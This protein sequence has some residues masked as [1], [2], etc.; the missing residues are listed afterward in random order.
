LLVAALVLL[1]VYYVGLAA[2]VLVN[3]ERV[4]ALSTSDRPAQVPGETWLLVGSDSREGLSAAERRR[5]RT[6]SA[7][8]QR[9]DTILLLH[10]P[11]SGSPTL[12]S[13][14]R[15]S[16]LTVPAY[17]RNGRQRGAH[18]DKLNAAYA[19]GGAPLLVRTVEQATGM[20]VDHYMEVGFAGVVGVVDAVGGVDLCVERAI[21]D[22]RAGLDVAAGCQTLD[23]PTA[24]GYV[25]TRYTDAR[26]DLARVE[27]QQ[28]F[29]AALVDAV[30]SPATLVNPI[31]M[32]RLAVAGTDAVR[33]DGGTGP[34]D[35][36]GAARAMRAVSGAR[37]TSRTVPI[38]DPN[39]RT[40]VGSA[41]LWDESEADALFE[42]LREGRTPPRA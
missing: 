22:R 23:G 31:A 13:L 21:R 36:L 11:R 25:R 41:V 10:V 14:P 1:V 12:V 3:L 32:T 24:L 35:I 30:A 39:A 19:L 6:G 7:D 20:R 29:L 40:P 27:R 37:G 5:L 34:L 16:Y 2:W 18:Q 8:G 9:T 15:D 28:R 38:A 26:G 4:E 17:R 33:V 42:A